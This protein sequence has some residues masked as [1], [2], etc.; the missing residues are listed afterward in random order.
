MHWW[1]E[2]GYPA[3]DKGKDG[4]P[5]TGQ[6]V[7]YYREQKKDETGKM[8]YTQKGLAKALGIKP[9]AVWNIENR[10]AE[11][12]NERREFLCTLLKIPPVLLGIITIEETL[13][14]IEQQKV[15]SSSSGGT[16]DIEGHQ[17][18]L[19]KAHA[20][21]QHSTAVLLLNAT[22]LKLDELYR[23]LPH[24][25]SLER[26]QIHELLYSYHIF[27][28]GEL[29]ELQQYDAALSH[30]DMAM[31]FANLLDNNELRI[32]CQ[33]HYVRILDVMDHAREAVQ[34]FDIARLNKESYALRSIGFTY[35]STLYA[36]V[37]TTE[38]DK[39]AAMALLDRGGSIV[40]SYPEQVYVYGL[41]SSLQGYYLRQG[42]TLASI[43]WNR[44]ALYALDLVQCSP[45]SWWSAYRDL[46]SAQ[47]YLNLGKYD[48]ATS[49]AMESALIARKFSSPMNIARIASIHS[50]ILASPYGKSS[51]VTE[52]GRLLKR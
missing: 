1:V 13:Q 51:D 48:F 11:L 30:L 50:Q 25:N 14:L 5:R 37:A 47:A 7:K 40:R 49:H 46:Y 22:K 15:L 42:S 24:V 43:G 9:K 36:K 6:V 39:K 23:Q 38:T 20:L 12:S 28:S 8:I 21:H 41:D 19:T 31:D 45:D 44:D 18:Y 3:F 32:V 27:M 26:P 16:I 52:L 29:R 34:I 17:K 4:R 35:M 33:L 10:D 2:L